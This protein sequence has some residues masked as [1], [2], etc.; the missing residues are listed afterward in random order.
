MSLRSA[1][2]IAAVPPNSGT[3]LKSVLELPK[4]VAIDTATREEEAKKIQDAID[5]MKLVRDARQISALSSKVYRVQVEFMPI[6]MPHMEEPF[7][8]NV[9]VSFFAED[10][11]KSVECDS[12][13]SI[14]E[15]DLLAK[16]ANMSTNPS[17]YREFFET[18]GHA[19]L[20]FRTL[21]EPFV[22]LSDDVLRPD[23]ETRRAIERITSLDMEMTCVPRNFDTGVLA[24]EIC[25]KTFSRLAP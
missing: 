4:R 23:S 9:R 13:F 15:Y 14:F 2:V 8:F 11:G 22:I 7:R 12:V 3:R 16:I 19:D 5:R 18:V 20:V 1:P 17:D 24:F 25:Q 10:D 6:R 21:V